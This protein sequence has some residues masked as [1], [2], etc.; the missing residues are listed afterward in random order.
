MSTNEA[1]LFALR[2]SRGKKIAKELIGNFYDRTFVTDRFAAYNYLPD[3]NR[4]VCW[5][6]L[7]RDFTKISERKGKILVE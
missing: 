7:L 2:R 4:Q 3:K 6:H 1:T 5:A